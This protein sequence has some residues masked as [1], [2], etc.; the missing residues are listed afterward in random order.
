MKEPR[1]SEERFATITPDKEKVACKN[2]MFRLSDAKLSDGSIVEQYTKGRCD[3][4]ESK[5]SEILFEN[6]ACEYYERE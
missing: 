3:I 5:P 4:Y 1:W 6:T 2:C